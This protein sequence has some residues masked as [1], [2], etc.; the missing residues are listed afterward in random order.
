[1]QKGFPS[2]KINSKLKK[3]SPPTKFASNTKNNLPPHFC[4]KMTRGSLCNFHYCY[5][6]Q[7]SCKDVARMLQKLIYN[8]GLYN[9]ATVQ[10]ECC[11]IA[12]TLFCS[13]LQFLQFFADP[14][15]FQMV[16]SRNTNTNSIRNF[17]ICI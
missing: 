15:Y 5:R 7:R 1:M 16:N 9:V 17:L 14:L 4:Y 2:K 8:I 12:A 3:G 6:L 13:F 11:N 10:Q